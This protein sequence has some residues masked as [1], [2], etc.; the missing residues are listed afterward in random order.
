M[1]TS[2]CPTVTHFDEGR[3]HMNKTDWFSGQPVSIWSQFI[4]WLPAICKRNT[5]F[6]TLWQY[7]CRNI[8]ISYYSYYQI[9]SIVK[10]KILKIWMLFSANFPVYVEKLLMVSWWKISSI[11]LPN[12]VKSLCLNRRRIQRPSPKRR[13]LLHYCTN[14]QFL[15]WQYNIFTKKILEQFQHVRCVKFW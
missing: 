13:N 5:T 7:C 10:M 4:F 8:V 12:R 6:E 3:K 1:C 2:V 14:L 15:F 9:L 11:I